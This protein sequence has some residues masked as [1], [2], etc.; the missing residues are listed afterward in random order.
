MHNLKL[1]Y[2]DTEEEKMDKVPT[3]MEELYSISIFDREKYA[4]LEELSYE[5]TCIGEVNLTNE[6]K[7]VL[8][9]HPKF[10]VIE[11]LEEETLEFEQELS[12]GKLRM[13][14]NKEIEME[15]EDGEK[16]SPE[17]E[18]KLEEEEAKSRLTFDPQTKVYNDRKRRVTDLE[19]CSRITLPQPLPTKYETSIEMRR[20]VH[21]NI[22]KE[23]RKEHCNKRGEQA[24]N[25]TEEQQQGLK[26]LQENH[27][28]QNR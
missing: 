16:M 13:T 27:S 28:P 5:I 2:R 7:S 20:A 15:K 17:T 19:E 23:H 8:R 11:I 21:A 24:P 22:Y 3:E 12:N 1:K 14:L 6:I 18:E 26:S 25:L 10:S 4:N 9:L